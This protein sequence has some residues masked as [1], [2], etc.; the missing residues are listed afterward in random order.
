M[1][2]YYAW[3]IVATALVLMMTTP[4]LALF[5]G[6][7]TRAKS[8]LNMMMM[9]YIAMAIVGIVCVLWGW[10]MS[11]GRDGRHGTASSPTR[12]PCSASRTS[13]HDNYIYV[14]FQLT[15]AVDH[16]GAD[17]RRDRRPREAVVLDGLPAA[18]DHALLLPDRPHG[19]GRGGWICTHFA[20]Q[21]YAGGTVGAHQRRC[22]GPAC[23]R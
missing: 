21:D 16:R 18:L 11:F 6:G 1:D 14:M 2:G 9:S 8:V 7:M 13:T 10:S 23:S 15:F 19:A 4:A 22:G 20:A 5:Y 3:M 17:L 12:S